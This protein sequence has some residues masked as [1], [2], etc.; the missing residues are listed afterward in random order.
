MVSGNSMPG[1]ICRFKLCVDMPPLRGQE[2]LMYHRYTVSGK[3]LISLLIFLH[4]AVHM[5]YQAEN[6]TVY[7]LLDFITN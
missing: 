6:S 4:N 7:R 5:K 3:G 1:I 2:L